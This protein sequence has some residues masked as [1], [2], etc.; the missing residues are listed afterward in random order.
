MGVG[1]FD[2]ITVENVTSRYFEV[3]F[4]QVGR[5]ERYEDVGHDAAAAVDHLPPGVV[6]RSASSK[7]IE[8]AEKNSLCW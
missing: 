8:S 7:R 4:G 5:V 2:R 1:V 6:R 3:I